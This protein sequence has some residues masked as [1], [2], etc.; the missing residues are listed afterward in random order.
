[1]KKSLFYIA[2]AALAL[3]SCNEEELVQVPVNQV[4]GVLT[5]AFEQDGATRTNITSTTNEGKTSN[6][7]A[8]S[9]GDEIAVFGGTAVKY[10]ISDV[11]AGIFQVANGATAPAE[12]TGVAFPYS[13]D[14]S[15]TEN[16]LTMT[17]PSVIDQTTAGELDLP[18][19]ATVSEGN[20]T[21][22]HLAGVLK[23]NLAEV[24]AGYNTLTVTAD[25]PISGTF[26]ATTN[27]A[28]PVLVSS[29]EVG[30][31]KTVTVTFAGATAEPNDYTLYLP[32]PVGGYASIVVSVT[33]GTNTKVLKQ[34]TDKTVERAQVYS[35]SADVDTYVT[36]ADELVA[37]VAAENTTVVN[38]G[39]D[40]EM[41][42][43]L[44]IN[45]NIT[46]NGNGHTLT[47]SAGRAINV[48]VNATDVTIKNLVINSTGER[49]INIINSKKT[50]AIDN[51]TA[52]TTN[53]AV[54]VA[55][56]AP[57]VT[58]S[59]SNSN[60]TGLN[61]VNIAGESSQVT[62]TNTNL[63]CDD[64]NNVEA[65]GAISIHNTGANSTV[66]M[67]SGKITVG[68]D[69]YA[70]YSSADN[71]SITIVAEEVQVEQ[72]ADNTNPT[73]GY[74]AC[75]IT[76]SNQTAYGFNSIEAALEKVQ[77]GETIYLVKDIILSANTVIPANV[78]IDGKDKSV[79]T[80]E[81]EGTSGKGK[82]V[83][84]LAG[85]TIKNINFTS[86]N[87]QY[88]IIVTAGGSVIENCQFE[89]VSAVLTS[90]GGTQTYGKRAIFTGSTLDLTGN[91][92]VKNCT[93]DDQV[94]AFNFS[95]AKNQMTITFEDCTLGG[96]LSGHGASHTF[97]NCT[98]KT[99]G[100]YAN[101]IPYCPATFNGC[102]FVDDFAI[103]LKK[104]STY[105]FD[106]SCKRVENDTETAVTGPDILKWDFS[107][108]G[109]DNGVDETVIIGESSWKNSSIVEEG[110]TWSSVDTENN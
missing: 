74:G 44:T 107:G 82:G 89:T 105:R 106:S 61:V 88:D 73:I 69:S 21:L 23:V 13:E 108:D 101:Y 77:N 33:D 52:T 49:A 51:V 41:S 48:D 76:Y 83:F 32:L 80:N 18:M 50:V 39:G 6:T 37:A 97:D 16:T 96:W 87:T 60:L 79:S 40:I 1:M 56:S 91:L 54:M 35:T 55:T 109:T 95:N 57:E 94:Y 17:L 20:I 9:E 25:K 36:T 66:T 26:T 90:E 45:K 3:V 53:Y 86:P 110:I 65:Y 12:I 58:L 72:E 78:T 99:S 7:L 100:N 102:T 70:A 10:T 11:K 71:V 46:L 34:W 24:P 103:S 31:N 30:A 2:A 4:N 5:V 85:G 47:S 19:W 27:A 84:Q 59:I 43:I 67:N 98:F 22:K 92:T 93:F 62:I 63:T 42:E 14:V 81:S 29:S 38:L 104:G 75:Y 15:L 68:G 28:D 8:W 64:Q